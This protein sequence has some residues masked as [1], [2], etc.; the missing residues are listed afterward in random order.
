[1][2][3]G[4]PPLVLDAPMGKLPVL[5]YMQGETRFRMVERMNPTRFR[6]FAVAS[7][8]AAERRIA[9]YKHIAQLRLPRGSEEEESA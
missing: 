9:T 3:E 5:Q 6:E 4:K 1:V 7:Q 2:D 8:E